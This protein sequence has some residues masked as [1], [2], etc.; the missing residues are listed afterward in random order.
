MPRPF[1]EF[2]K[3][4]KYLHNVS[5][6]TLSW[7][8]ASWKAWEKYQPD[9]VINAR[10]AGVSPATVNCYLRCLNAYFRWAG[11]STIRRLKT[12]QRVLPVFSESQIN[13]IIQF[14]KRGRVQLL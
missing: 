3:E 2:V 8:A 14:R 9:F 7:Y 11:L 10:E 13:R 12:E 1:A 4:R 6:A 5:P